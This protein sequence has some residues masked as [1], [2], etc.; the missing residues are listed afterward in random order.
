VLVFDDVKRHFNFE[1]LF[2]VITEG[3]TIEYKG[4]DSIKLDVTESPKIII[5]TN[6][7]IKGDS[8][9]FNARKYEVEMSSYF[10]DKYTPIMQFGHEL[11]NDWSEEQWAYFDAYMLECL[12][13]YLCD[14]LIEM[15]V[16][17][18][19]FRKMID[20]I[21]NDFYQFF[22]GLERNEFKRVKEL[23]DDFIMQYPERKKDI[24]QNR[25][26]INYKR[27]AAFQGYEVDDQRSGGITK[28]RMVD[29]KQ[30]I[31]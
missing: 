9:S 16:K 27:Y 31:F 18:L 23:Y 29:T 28:L 8:A 5:T 20:T 26:T 1:Q 13:K 6:Y 12:R 15:P 2:S 19:D 7:T 24:T 10:N 3:I 14:G 11:F 4:K 25:L 21:G 17:N 22:E 30:D